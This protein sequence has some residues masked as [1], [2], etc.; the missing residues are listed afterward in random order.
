MPRVSSFMNAVAFRLLIGRSIF[1][2]IVWSCPRNVLK[3]ETCL[4]QYP[5]T[6]RYKTC[7]AVRVPVM[8]VSGQRLVSLDAQVF[9]RKLP[10]SCS[11][12]L[13]RCSPSLWTICCMH[14]AQFVH[15]KDVENVMRQGCVLIY[16][17]LSSLHHSLRGK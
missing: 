14:G 13:G 7:G 12:L 10:V 16:L 4:T 3:R 17:H 8:H 2:S 15:I 11:C 5:H 1:F 9:I 6:K